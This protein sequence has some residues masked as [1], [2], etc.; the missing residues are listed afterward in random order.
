M[1][2]RIPTAP[3][4]RRV[5]VVIAFVVLASASASA[6][7]RPAAQ[8]S[9]HPSPSPSPTPR[10]GHA[11]QKNFLKNILGDQR[12]IWTSPLRAGGDAKW[13]VPLGGATAVL[14]ATDHRTA[15]WM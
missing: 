10:A 1:G 5:A 3:G 9:P 12:D 6:Q 4:P 8:P 7:S 11:L 13:L 14:L 15:C 2:R